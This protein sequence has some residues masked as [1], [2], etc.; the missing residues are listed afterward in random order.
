MPFVM[1]T[2]NDTDQSR[3]YL[4]YSEFGPSLRTPRSQRLAAEF[5]AVDSRTL[6][7]WLKDFEEMDKLIWKLALEGGKSNFHRDDFYKSLSGA[8]HWLD[9]RGL[10]RAWSRCTYYIVHEGYGSWRS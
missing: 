1:D 6:Q 2:P 9:K 3:A 4:V 7:S 8:Y 5:P 10:D